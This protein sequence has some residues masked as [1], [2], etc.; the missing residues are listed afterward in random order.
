MIIAKQRISGCTLTL[1]M[2]PEMRWGGPASAADADVYGRKWYGIW[3]RA[4]E[5][6]RAP[7]EQASYKAVAY[8]WF[9]LHDKG[10][11]A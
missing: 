4:E 7:E 5:E 10:G 8:R 2:H 1:R 6:S 3:K 11:N 9:A